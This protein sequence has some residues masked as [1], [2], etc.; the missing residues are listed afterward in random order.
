MTIRLVFKPLAEAEIAEAFAWYAQPEIGQGEAFID[1]LER[2]E[3]F[4]RL[5]PLLYPCVQDEIH[6]ANL[7]RFPYSLFYVVD[8]E[9]VSVLSCFHQHRD[10]GSRPGQADS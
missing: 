9:T 3:R 2:V 5:N 1:E 8:D 6:R 7:R 4:I 10:P